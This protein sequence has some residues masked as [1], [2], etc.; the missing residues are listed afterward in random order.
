MQRAQFKT[1]AAAKYCIFIALTGVFGF[2]IAE[3]FA[4]LFIPQWAPATGQVTRF[5]QYDPLLGWAHIPGTEGVFLSNGVE[6]DVI[7]NAAGFRDKNVDFDRQTEEMR[8]LVLGDSLAWGFGVNGANMVT[9]K[10]EDLLPGVEAINL[11]VSG[12]STDQ[13]LLLYKEL[14]YRYKADLVVLVV[15]RNDLRGNLSKKEY[16]IY[17]KPAF[18]WRGDNLVAVNQPVEKTPM[19]QRLLSQAA[20]HSYILTAAART[21]H[22][23]SPTDPPAAAGQSPTP[24]DEPPENRGRR[25]ENSP[26]F[27]MLVSLINELQKSITDKQGNVPLLVMFQDGIPHGEYLAE[28][29][30]ELEFDSVLLDDY[31]TPRDPS[32][33]VEDLLH[34][35]PAGNGIVAQVIADYIR[36][37]FKGTAAMQ[38]DEKK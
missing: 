20:M 12:Y 2:A 18:E 17:G 15:A 10:L 32:T 35:N 27:H 36:E 34:W 29:M 8:V 23:L 7:I 16:L 9:S 22:E 37:H 30:T 6:T 19:I 3:G 14:G 31:L 28:Q 25:F 33:H 38:R 4:R 13:E 1:K 5:W 11:A 26:R 21:I 24:S